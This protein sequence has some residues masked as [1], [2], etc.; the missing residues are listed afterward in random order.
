MRGLSLAAAITSDAISCASQCFQRPLQASLAKNVGLDPPSTH[1]RSHK[2]SAAIL[3]AQSS[4]VTM[5]DTT[6]NPSF[7]AMLPAG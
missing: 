5:H 7:G 3:N 2:Q 6:E 4:R 1:K